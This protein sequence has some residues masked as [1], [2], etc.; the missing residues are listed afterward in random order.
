MAREPNAVRPTRR[1]RALAAVARLAP[2]LLTLAALAAGVGALSYG[3]WLIEPRAGWIT[4][5]ATLL[6][7]ATRE[8]RG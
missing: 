1:G 4:L 7:I 2:G 8:R 5:G 3:A 6:W